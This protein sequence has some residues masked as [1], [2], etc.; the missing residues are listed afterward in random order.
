MNRSTD[1]SYIGVDHALLA[2]IACRFTD[3]GRTKKEMKRR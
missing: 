2:S 1:K 3:R